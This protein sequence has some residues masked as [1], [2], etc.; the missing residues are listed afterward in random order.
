M[1][2]SSILTPNS[3]AYQ[4]LKLLD[5]AS[6]KLV[7]LTVKV[8]SLAKGRII[9]L[10]MFSA[11]N[12][13][14]ANLFMLTKPGTLVPGRIKKKNFYGEE[15]FGRDREG[16]EQKK[17]SSK[18]RRKKA[19]INNFSRIGGFQW[20]GRPTATWSLKGGSSSSIISTTE[21]KNDIATIPQEFFQISLI[22]EIVESFFQSY[23]LDDL[24]SKQLFDLLSRRKAIFWRSFW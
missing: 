19:L 16:E 20:K 9:Q 12:Q 18:K 13:S 24:L 8:F 15:D 7:F 2:S 4:S 23:D 1:N 3:L 22:N 10:R 11:P 21:Y 14:V 6:F 5:D 17:M